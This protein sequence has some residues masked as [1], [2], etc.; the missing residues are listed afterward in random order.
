MDQVT[1][2]YGVIL[3]ITEALWSGFSSQFCF[4]NKENQND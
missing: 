4:K 3:V 1:I 2:E